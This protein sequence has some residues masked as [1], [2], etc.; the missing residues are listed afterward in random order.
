MQKA[1]DLPTDEFVPRLQFSTAVTLLAQV[2]GWKLDTV[3]TTR[4][5]TSFDETF[6]EC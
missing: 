6:D 2:V 4:W 3:I 1:L 5:S